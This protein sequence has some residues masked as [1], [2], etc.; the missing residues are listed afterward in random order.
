M[1]A[2]GLAPAHRP[3]RSIGNGQGTGWRREQE[4]YRCLRVVPGYAHIYMRRHETTNPDL[5]SWDCYDGY[6]RIATDSLAFTELS[7]RNVNKNSLVGE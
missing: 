7:A 6:V 4:T 3:A 1:P 2:P 5:V